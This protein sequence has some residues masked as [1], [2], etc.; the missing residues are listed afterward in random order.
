VTGA[1]LKI[2][3]TEHPVI[4]VQGKIGDAI[5]EASSLEAPIIVSETTFFTDSLE[6]GIEGIFKEAEVSYTLDGSVPDSTSLKYT[7]AIILEKSTKLLAITQ[8]IGWKPSTVNEVDFKKNS[9]S[10]E[11]VSLSVLPD[12]KYQAQL[13]NTLI[14]PKTWFREFRRRTMGRLRGQ[15]RKAHHEA[16]YPT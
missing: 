4:A 8:K 2:F 15:K 13:G 9:V 5:F 7:K 3:I 11:A 16:R 1:I 6:M 10:Y 14:D 12:G